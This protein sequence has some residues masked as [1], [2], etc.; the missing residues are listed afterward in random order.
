[1]AGKPILRAKLEPEAEAS[2]LAGQRVVAF[3]GIGRPEKFFHMLET[4]GATLVEAYSF[5][6]HYPYQASEVG[7][8]ITIAE[9]H[10]AAL[11]TTS[12]DIVRVP[13]HQRDAIGVLRIVVTW[14]DEIALEDI[15]RP[16]MTGGM[17][18]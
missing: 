2:A 12:K 8:L 6:D 13:A 1:V 14:E 17:A 15:L 16:A 9:T 3:A 7:E 4:L 18:L 5:P 11:I 10:A